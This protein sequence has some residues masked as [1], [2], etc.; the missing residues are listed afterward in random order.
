VISDRTAPGPNGFPT[1][2]TITRAADQP[3]DGTFSVPRAVSHAGDAAV[4]RFAAATQI[5]TAERYIAMGNHAGAAEHLSASARQF[6]ALGDHERAGDL[7]A[8]ASRQEALAGNESAAHEAQAHSEQSRA[9]AR[10]V[11]TGR[12]WPWR[13]HGQP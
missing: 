2:T 11:A 7:Y 3:G 10:P 9:A 5:V 8:Q 6:E 12:R 4:S 13:N 1:R